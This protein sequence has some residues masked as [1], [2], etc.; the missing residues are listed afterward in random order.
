MSTSTRLATPADARAIHD[1]I[2]LYVPSGELLPRSEDFVALRA[3][4]FVVAERDGRV[5]GCAHLDEYAPSLAE[6][7][8]L[9]VSPDAQGQGVGVALVAGIERLAARR[10]FTT[11]FAVSNS[12]A[13]FAKLGY[14]ERDVP[15][16]NRE[17]S[18][19]SRWK[20]VHAKELQ[21]SADVRAV[22]AR[23]G[24]V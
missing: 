22:D 19:V 21:A 15:E 9:A 12:A 24:S 16:L 10:G 13:F 17:R 14:E 11:L 20:A 6:L 7:R 3:H 1:L 5:V 4:E 8:S 18:E 23:R 2:Q